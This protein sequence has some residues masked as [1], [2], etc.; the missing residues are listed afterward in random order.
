MSLI[1]KDNKRKTPTSMANFTPWLS[2]IRVSI[3]TRCYSHERV[4]LNSK[5]AISALQFLEPKV[6]PIKPSTPAFFLLFTLDYLVATTNETFLHK[7]S[8]TRNRCFCI[9][10]VSV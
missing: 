2:N 1:D 3:R 9:W 4:L 10:D 6:Q 5:S 8:I 7:K